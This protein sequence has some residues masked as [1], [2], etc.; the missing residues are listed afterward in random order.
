MRAMRVHFQAVIWSKLDDTVIEVSKWGQKLECNRFIPVQF[1]GDVA[2]EHILTVVR[3]R[4]KG[5][6]S[7]SLGSCQK[8]GLPCVTACSN[9]HGTDCRNFQTDVDN[10][11]E[12]DTGSDP[13]PYVVDAD[14]PDFLWDDDLNFQF[15]EV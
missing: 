4:C 8:H 3:C 10:T 7:S 11:C 12:S 9:C 1:K 14:M 2:P 6:C 5:T 13:D 15:E